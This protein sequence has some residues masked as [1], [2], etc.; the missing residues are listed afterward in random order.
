MARPT[1]YNEQIHK[2]LVKLIKGCNYISTACAACRIDDRTF[3]LWQSKGKEYQ[4]YIENNPGKPIP[5]H[6][7]SSKVYYQL[8]LDIKAA[9]AEAEA[10]ALK[11]ITDAMPKNWAAAATMMS[12]RWKDRWR[13]DTGLA[14]D[15]IKLGLQIMERLTSALERPGTSTTVIDQT[16]T[17]ALPAPR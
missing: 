2:R 16:D 14:Q 13:D 5:S 12:R 17:P 9:D 1:K 8:M 11:T 7:A 4:A 6:L 15:S 10:A 3:Y